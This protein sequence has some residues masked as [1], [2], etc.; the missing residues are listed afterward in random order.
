MN[1]VQARDDYLLYLEVEKNYSINTLTSYAIDLRLFGDFLQ[2]NNRSIFLDDI[3]SS[4]MQTII[5]TKT[6]KRL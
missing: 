3:N 6:I 5:F 1:Y 2:N 4:S